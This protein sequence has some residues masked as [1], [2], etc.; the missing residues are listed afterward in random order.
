MRSKKLGVNPVRSIPEPLDGVLLSDQY[1]SVGP[2]IWAAPSGLIPVDKPIEGIIIKAHA[3]NTGTIYITEQGKGGA[4]H[5]FP[6]A[7]SES[8]SLGIDDFNKV[9]IWIPTT[10]DGFSYLAIETVV[11]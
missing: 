3:G 1:I 7:K 6:L 4:A 10:G 9:H 11:K 8:V 2:N 5:G